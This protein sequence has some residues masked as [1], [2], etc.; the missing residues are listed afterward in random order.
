M[1]EGQ[2]ESVGGLPVLLS[3]RKLRSLYDNPFGG[4]AACGKEITYQKVDEKNRFVIEWQRM[5]NME[6]KRQAKICMQD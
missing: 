1:I 6:N 2:A 4:C 3:Y 5:M